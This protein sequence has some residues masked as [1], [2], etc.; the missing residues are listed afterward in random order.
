MKHDI[1]QFKSQLIPIYNSLRD[2][3][4]RD[5]NLCPFLMQWGNRFPITPNSGII[6]YGRATN[7]WFGTWDYDIFFSNNDE[8][9]GWNR[10]NQM[11]WVEEQWCNSEDGYDT[12][13]S[14]FWSIIKGISTRFYGDEWFKYVAWSNI[15][16]VAP[17]SQGNP[18]D[19]V[20]YSTLENNLK[21]FHTE[22]DFWSPK[23]IVLFTDGIK[24][25]NK[26]TIDWTS[27]YISSLNNGIVPSTIY[28]ISWDSENPHIKIKVYKLDNR[29]IILSLH[30]QGRKV[31]LHRDA[32]I[33]IIENIERKRL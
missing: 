12:S 19:K 4:N 32:I 8:D 15:C 20:F 33:N 23:Y 16:K 14:Q 13:K 17:Y 27:N 30:P 5:D 7:G 26:A 29:F 18:S 22:L 2:D 9:R 11:A 28:D 25:D 1:D 10:D 24:R 6:F 31:E 21:V 3:C